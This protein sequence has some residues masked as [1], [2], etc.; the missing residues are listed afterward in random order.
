MERFLS[1][2]RRHGDHEPTPNPS[3]EGIGR[4]ADKCLLPS[5]AGSG[6]GRFIESREENPIESAA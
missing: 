2:L 1:L 3:H 5:K 6:V 4:D